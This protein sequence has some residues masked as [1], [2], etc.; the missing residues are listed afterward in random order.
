MKHIRFMSQQKVDIIMK[1]LVRLS[2]HI[3]MK[4][5]ILMKSLIILENLPRSMTLKI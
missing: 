5:I 1:E 4:K 2:G 3:G